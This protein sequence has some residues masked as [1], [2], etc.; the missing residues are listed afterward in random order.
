M[1]Q[2]GQSSCCTA[3]VTVLQACRGSDGQKA[4]S[5]TTSPCFAWALT[6]GVKLFMMRLQSSQRT[7]K[8]GKLW[9]LVCAGRVC[10]TKIRQNSLS[11]GYAANTIC[12]MLVQ[13]RL[14][15]I[16]EN[17][18]KVESSWKRK[19]SNEGLTTINSMVIFY[20]YVAFYQITRGQRILHD[21]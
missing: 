11:T 2:S 18:L 14:P 6:T 5:R 1:D 10:C 3:S 21:Q 13:V 15:G 19:C 4:P 7:L 9:R 8:W 16:V 20:S 12:I 17:A